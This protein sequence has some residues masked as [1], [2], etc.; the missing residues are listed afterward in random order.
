MHWPLQLEVLGFRV[1][2][3][4]SQ[5]P[6]QVGSP[7][8]MSEDQASTEI[9]SSATSAESG[10][11]NTLC[12]THS[13][14]VFMMRQPLHPPERPDIDPNDETPGMVSDEDPETPNESEND[15]AERI[16]KNKA[17]VARKR[18]A[19]HCRESLQWYQAA[20]RDYEQELQ[21][22]R[23]LDEAEQ[24]R[25]ASANARG[26]ANRDH[27]RRHAEVSRNL[28]PEFM[29]V[30]G[31]RVY[32]IPYANIMGARENSSPDDEHLK[33]I[34]QCTL[35]QLNGR[36][37]ASIQNPRIQ[38]Q[39]DPASNRAGSQANQL[40]GSRNLPHVNARDLHNR[41]SH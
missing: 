7:L 14:E 24:N 15:K 39:P 31:T 11:G 26:F 1:V 4:L 27:D 18:R 9:L 25:A 33:N 28:E 35:L 2:N 12:Y 19:E 41:L 36:N 37:L 30:A 40:R 6:F 8:P 17:K 5:L 34:L 16:K 38:E 29:E 32:T 10:M 13:R 21:R 20:L 3:T 22:Q 23:L